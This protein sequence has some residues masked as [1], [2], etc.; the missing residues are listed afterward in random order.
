MNSKKFKY[1][2]LMSDI[3]IEGFKGMFYDFSARKKRISSIFSPFERSLF[4]EGLLSFELLS[5][6]RIGIS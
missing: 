2:L 3:V 6:R 4:F 5:F 1:L